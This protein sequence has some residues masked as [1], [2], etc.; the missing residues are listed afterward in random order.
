M[1]MVSAPNSLGD[2]FDIDGFISRDC[3]APERRDVPTKSKI[4]FLGDSSMKKSNTSSSN[5]M[6]IAPAQRAP[7][8]FDPASLRLDSASIPHMGVKKQVTVVPVRKP[9][10]QVFVRVHPE[11]AYRLTTAII[12]LKEDDESYL[13]VPHLHAALAAEITPVTLFLAIDRQGNVF[14]WP[15]KLPKE[16]G[17]TNDWN[18][19]SM[20]AAEVAS[21]SWI[22]LQSNRGLGAYDVLVAAEKL[23]DPEWPELSMRDILEIAFRGKYIDD[24]NHAVIKKLRGHA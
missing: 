8:P 24:L 1:P 6:Y 3:P 14:L 9:N 12:E 23:P 19:S 11:D 16:D 2:A 20:A 21:T 18:T 17:R 22:R 15:V 13:V 10:R 4:P 7:D 5:T